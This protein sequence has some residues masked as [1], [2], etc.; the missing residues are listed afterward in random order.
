MND[1][2]DRYLWAVAKELPEDMRD[3]V[4]GELRA[5]IADMV[6]AR[7]ADA[8]EADAVREVLV[9]LGDP[10]ELAARYSGKKRYL[11]GPAAY[12]L[13][14]RLLRTLMLVIVPVVLAATLIERLRSAEDDVLAGILGAVNASLLAGVM[15]AFWVTLVFA[16]L[17]RAGV[18]PDQ[19]SAE[20]GR[21]WAPDSLPPAAEKR[22]I[23]LAGTIF[24]L[25]AL[26]L[27]VVLVLWLRS[28][29]VV[30]L[31]TGRQWMDV[32]GGSIPFL[33]DGLWDFWMPGL[34]AVIAAGMAIEIW[35][36][37]SGR[38]TLPLVVANIVAN[39]LFAGVVLAVLGT[40]Q[41]VD[42]AFLAAFEERTG[43]AFPGGVAGTALA[44][45]VTLICVWDSI[46]C[47]LAYLRARRAPAERGATGPA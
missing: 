7:G 43:T 19:P 31:F 36:Y 46:G 21:A 33:D 9:E 26:S 10:A 14:A 15:V 11:I 8:D 29:S 17:E 28:H 6:E 24:S 22:Q 2:I 42:P 20:G 23:T 3:D 40:Q 32:D 4:A 16:V 18:G 37:L 39:A 34:V 13:Y 47:L 5:T 45:V 30:Q 25:V 35:K 41:V 1:L 12:P 38:W 44:V 27:L